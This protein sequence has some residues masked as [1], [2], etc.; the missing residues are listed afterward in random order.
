[1]SETEQSGPRDATATTRARQRAVSATLPW[2]DRHDVED[3][4]RGFI[5]SLPEV[6][7]TNAQGRVVWS[8][9]D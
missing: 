2:H 3:A 5:G 9:R 7:I 1:M 6:E 4:A 8:L